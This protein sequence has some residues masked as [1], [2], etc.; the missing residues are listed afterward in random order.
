MAGC[1]FH[2]GIMRVQ[3]PADGRQ[4]RH[5]ASRIL[6]IRL[7]KFENHF[8]SSGFTL[9]SKYPPAQGLVLA[10][11]NCLQSVDWR[12]DQ[13]AGRDGRG[14]CVGTLQAWMPAGAF[15]A[16]VLA[17]PQALRR[18]VLDNR[19]GAGQWRGRV[20]LGPRRVWPH[21]GAGH[22]SPWEFCLVWALRY[23]LT[24]VRTISVFSAFPLGPP[25]FCG[26]GAN[27]NKRRRA[28]GSS[29]WSTREHHLLFTGG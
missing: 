13:E 14:F 27:T 9:R 15:L 8:T 2:P 23:F 25:F 24:A 11:G 4:V 5:G 18:F 28:H 7:E 6:P 10:P 1:M 29:H 20:E 17:A 21:S 22:R 26:F 3:R 16:G 12:P 19:I